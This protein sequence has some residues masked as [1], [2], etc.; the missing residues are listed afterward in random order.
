MGLA[1]LLSLDLEIQAVDLLAL[2]PMAL[3]PLPSRGNSMLLELETK[4]MKP[5]K[6]V[7]EKD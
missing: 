7:G 2:D 5:W 1:T 3:D 6:E 4:R